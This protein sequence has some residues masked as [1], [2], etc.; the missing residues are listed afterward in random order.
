MHEVNV[1]PP[2]P[3]Q[4]TDTHT[5]AEQEGPDGIGS[6]SLHERQEPAR[7]LGRPV[8]GN[9]A[10]GLRTGYK[11]HWI[12]CHDPTGQSQLERPGE[13]GPSQSDGVGSKGLAVLHSPALDQA[14]LPGQQDLGRDVADLTG[15]EKRADVEVGVA[16]VVESR[17]G[18]QPSV[19]VQPVQVQV[20][21]AIDAEARAE[22][23][24]PLVDLAQ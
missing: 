24:Q 19:R 14:S 20:Q 6:V 1:G 7:V 5:T 3:H 4:L 10:L 15:P 23:Y 13:R 11:A 9:L 16:A 12:H 2:Q 22:T 8:L 18:G 21:Q 17:L